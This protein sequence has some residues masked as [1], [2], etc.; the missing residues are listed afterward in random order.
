MTLD[1]KRS[2]EPPGDGAEGRGDRM[3]DS[4]AFVSGADQQA[5]NRV[6]QKLEPGEFLGR[7]ADDD[8]E[9]K[10]R[11]NDGEDGHESAFLS[12]RRNGGRLG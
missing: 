8:A 5:K 11:E 1:R 10:N 7:Q 9:D 3:G 4:Q 6:H 12:E 2:S